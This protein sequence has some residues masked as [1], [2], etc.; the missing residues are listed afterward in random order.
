MQLVLKA[1]ELNREESG[2][3]GQDAR[4]GAGWVSWAVRVVLA[5]GAVTVAYLIMAE[6]SPAAVLDGRV[7]SGGTIPGP[8]GSLIGR[9]Q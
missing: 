8:L 4:R 5:L 1:D 2:R 9:L 6:T 7:A 3:D